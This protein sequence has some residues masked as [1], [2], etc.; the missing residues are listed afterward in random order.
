MRLGGAKQ[1][2][3]GLTAAVL[4]ALAVPAAAQNAGP[5]PLAKSPGAEA[6]PA[7]I[8][9]DSV[10][11]DENLG[12]VTA[13]GNVSTKFVVPTTNTSSSRRNPSISVRSWLTIEC[14]TP[15]PV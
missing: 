5:S 10:T 12:V 11:Y 9:A 6:I 14:S 13:T 7:L 8:S 2:I 4:L 15:E 1:A 3:M